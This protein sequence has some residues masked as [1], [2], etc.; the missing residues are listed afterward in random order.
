MALMN[1]ESLKHDALPP[2]VDF[3]EASP[4][5]H[6]QLRG[7]A[8][9]TL[10][11][12]RRQIKTNIFCLVIWP[13]LIVVA[14][15]AL[16]SIGRT[17]IPSRDIDL[18]YC[19][20]EADPFNDVSFDP[21]DPKGDHF[22]ARF[23]KVVDNKINIAHFPTK[24]GPY[25]FK[26]LPCI[27]WFGDNIPIKNP[28][29][30]STLPPQNEPHTHYTPSPAGSW[31]NLDELLKQHP[32]PPADGGPISEDET[33][34]DRTFRSFS[35]IEQKVFISYP[36]S[37][38][39]VVGQ[40]PNV[41]VNFTTP[42]TA[43]WPPTDPS[44]VY[45][46]PNNT[47]SSLLGNIP[48]R[49]ANDIKLQMDGPNPREK[50]G[51]FKTSKFFHLPD[52]VSMENK[53]L[54]M[55]SR[56]LNPP[57][58]YSTGKDGSQPIIPE[59][60]E[61]DQP[62]GGLNIDSLDM[63]Q[64]RLK[65]TM[66]MAMTPA[67]AGV[68]YAPDDKEYAGLRQLIT[69]SQ[70][71]ASMMKHKFGSNFTITQGLRIMPYIWS[72]KVLPNRSLNEISSGLFPFALSFLLPTIVWLLVQEKEDRHRM[73]MAMNGLRGFAYYL[74]H[75]IEFMCMQLIM[76]L[77]FALA[78]TAIKSEFIWRTNP[79]FL[80]VLFLIW[81]HTQAT[82]AFFIASFFSR[83]RKA[84]L[85]VYFF[86]AVSCIGGS[87]ATIIFS[88]GVPVAW[89]IHPLFAFFHVIQIGI[90]H[91]SLVN[92]L[93]PLSFR[94]ITPGTAVFN[95]LMIMLGESVIFMVLTGYID[96]VIP[97]EYG[98]TR[99][100]HFPIS[101]WFKSSSNTA[102]DPEAIAVASH[103]KYH[104][105]SHDPQRI[106]VGADADVYTERDRVES[107]QYTPDK[108]PLILH[109]LFHQYPNK[110]EPALRG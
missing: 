2:P 15:F 102:Y 103:T 24:F 21:L 6:L 20:N 3:S 45:K 43:I 86:V 101:M 35:A 36:D 95:S 47:I 26:K 62:F 56:Q 38:K 9:K 77:V 94:D 90:M 1:K 31:F 92:G 17:P 25:S 78:A 74:A 60:F 19:V 53:V 76:C 93:L 64:L 110:V 108:T 37:L 82:F 100:W 66:Q 8:R 55:V 63:D 27:R 48:V 91:A 44:I 61:G 69:M 88:Q 28:Y 12:H 11:Y 68:R 109:N 98:V 97:S 5:L 85:L 13:I 33:M 81:S 67:A 50:I 58:H 59:E 49:Y 29:E 46:T 34:S 106:L 104:Q 52:A 70:M 7:L 54:E 41:T 40:F 22:N 14:A 73:M 42:S 57:R 107:S 39:N 4:S 99:P 75:Y 23:V 51:V 89:S 96:A 80:V 16:A 87:L 18:R 32:V 83:A 10:S 65:M 71:T 105:G 72:A 30:N 79:G 84:I